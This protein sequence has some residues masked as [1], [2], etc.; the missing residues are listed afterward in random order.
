MRA[1]PAPPRLAARDFVWS[2]RGRDQAALAGLTFDLEPGQVLLV[3]GPSGSGKSTLGR[4]L[5]G[6]VPHGLGGR[7]EGSLAIGGR[8]VPDTPPAVLGEQVGIVFQDPESQMVMPRVED[9]VAFGLENRG[10]S[11]ERMLG[12]VPETLAAVGLGGFEARSTASLS[13]GERQRL[14]LADVL[15]PLPGLLV[16][17]EPTA[18][19]D[20]PGTAAIFTHLAR[21]AEGRRHTIVVIE[22]RLAAVW[23][24][25]ERVLVLDARGRQVAF[26]APTAVGKLAG[27]ALAAA[28][29]WVPEAWPG[30]RPVPAAVAFGPELRP[31]RERAGPALLEAD[32]LGM[33]YPD[34]RGGRR[35][36]LDGVSLT[37]Q[38][39]ERVG[40]VGPNGSGK[41]SLL[42]ALA[43]LR[44]PDRGTV[45]LSS[46]GRGRIGRDAPPLD[47]ARLPSAELPAR[48]G[49]A[50]QDPE[51]GFVGRTVWAEVAAGRSDDRP[52]AVAVRAAL[53]RFGLTELAE[54]SPF[55][56]SRGEQRRLSLAALAVRRPEVL[57]LDEPTYGLD[58]ANADAVLALLDEGRAAG[59]GQV[60]ATH[61]PRL[62]PACDRVVALQAGRIV[63]DGS[64]ER[65]LAQPPYDPSG[66][67]RL[68]GP[69]L[70]RRRHAPVRP[71][72]APVRSQRAPGRPPRARA[73]PAP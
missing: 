2:Y 3:L 41:S 65:F 13:G 30:H 72:Q 15:A 64:P 57:L 4:A 49:L 71:R 56:L 46:D 67:W 18:D 33:E 12:R 60:L 53:Q 16:L 45:R 23:P 70:G 10:W 54:R 32:H 40:L 58:R 68:A 21:L 11:R 20:P 6:I 8:E 31:R 52:A 38:G 14:A 73:R 19:L 44:R 28:G 37:V 48:I 25:A 36:V 50:F 5:A 61:D 9:E 17:D 47:P 62:L 51:V 43:G 69:G 39:G 35:P 29:G 24:L 59:Q 27:T 26:G 66:P 1:D 7:W 55:Q 42:A 22:H 34:E 63:F